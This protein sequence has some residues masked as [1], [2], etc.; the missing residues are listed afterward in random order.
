MIFYKKKSITP[1]TVMMAPAISFQLMRSLKISTA[2]GMMSTGTM[3]MMVAAMPARV[4]WTASKEKETPRK[5]P[6]R[7]PRE[8]I[9]MA[10][11]LCKAPIILGHQ[12]ITRIIIKNP[13]MPAMTL[14]WE[15]AKAS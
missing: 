12:R 1:T 9:R 15:E 3:A 14:I 4:F 7:D 6:K 13:I 8:I 10:C 5:G 11:R 2:G